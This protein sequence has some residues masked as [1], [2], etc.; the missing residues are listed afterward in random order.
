MGWQDAPLVEEQKWKKA[1][2]AGGVDVSPIELP[3]R[4]DAGYWSGRITETSA[5]GADLA[6][7]G[8]DVTSG[9]PAGRF[10]A[11][12]SKDMN[13]AAAYMQKA[14]S[15]YYKQDIQIRLGPDSG[16]L[17]YLNPGTNRWTLAD[18]A[19]VAI[20]DFSDSGTLLPAVGAATGL[21]LGGP[22]P[23]GA[24]AS[25]VGAGA[26]EASRL[27]IG[28]IIGANEGI[29]TGEIAK[30]AIEAS[31][32]EALFVYGTT[33]VAGS[34]KFAK[35]LIS[36]SPVGE[37][38]AI[39]ALA[40]MDA[41]RQLVNDIDALSGVPF[42]PTTGQMAQDEYLLGLQT[43]YTGDSLEASVEV[44]R[45]LKENETSLEAVFDAITPVAE[46]P[47]VAGKAVQEATKERLAPVTEKAAADVLKKT[48]AAEEAIAA[49][50]DISEQ[51]AG[52]GLRQ[53][54]AEA[55]KAAKDIE[56]DAYETY[57][58][59]YGLG[60][61]ALSNVKI[62]P[63]DRFTTHME[64]LD[65][66]RVN[67]IFAG[68]KTGKGQLISEKLIS[69]QDDMIQLY[70]PDGEVLSEFP[71]GGEDLTIDLHQLEEGIKYLR[72]VIRKSPMAPAPDAPIND[73]RRLKDEMV[74]LRDEYLTKTDP[75]LLSL[76]HDAEAAATKRASDF[77]KSVLGVIIKKDGNK[78][79]LN[80]TRVFAYVIKSNDREAAEHLAK[81]LG[82]D[83]GAM[84]TAKEG[85]LSFYRREVAETG[86]VDPKLHKKFMRDRRYVI[87]ALFTPKEIQRMNL[88]GDMGKIVER[89]VKRYDNLMKGINKHFSGKIRDSSPENVVKTIFS[90]NFSS[91]DTNQ[92][93]RMMDAYGAGPQM[94]EAV[95]AFVRNK[96]FLNNRLN[97]NNLENLIYN[98]GD[99]LKQIFGPE[100]VV[101]LGKIRDASLMIKQTSKGLVP[102]KTNAFTD[103]MR[104]VFAPPL[105]RRGRAQTLFVNM[106]TQAARRAVGDAI[107]D[108]KRLEAV[109]R[110][111]AVDSK[112]KRAARVLSAIGAPLFITEPEP[113][114]EL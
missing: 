45:R 98:H 114:G 51:A 25:V 35:N 104:V 103:L 91:R 55:R 20:A 42:R 76:A 29:T 30:E 43:A 74:L 9:A 109:I 50:P 84:V 88:L 87:E 21:L 12:F 39:A 2:L 110:L 16:V 44:S 68:Q 100:Y 62:P 59:A 70:S 52:R 111:E 10:K 26:G 72:R 75:K 96:A 28:E 85:L 67:A 97:A 18:E 48:K 80:D 77:D 11:S 65:A 54:V 32:W 33:A 112:S 38:D 46:D 15:E 17:E 113:L 41:N 69:K 60:D 94:R 37:K 36:P 19:R 82:Q 99:K 7:K 107:M 14:L 83:P 31:L 23:V 95:G 53:E 79:M 6:R 61:D 106:R 102:R 92:L 24:A 90:K 58:R 3:S 47:Y 66:E 108:P 89:S 57:K 101:N 1:P 49:V 4:T 71:V 73:V 13:Y 5:P 8:I 86:F 81:I 105:T 64:T 93:M 40:Q 56:T 63:S 27:K 34:Y 22:T 78:Y